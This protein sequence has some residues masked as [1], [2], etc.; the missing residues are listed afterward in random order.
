MPGKGVGGSGSRDDPFRDPHQ[1]LVAAEKLRHSPDHP[2]VTVVFAGG[3][4]H[5]TQP[6]VL[7]AGDPSERPLILQSALGQRAV[8]SL[9]TAVPASAFRPVTDAALLARMAPNARG[10]IAALDLSKHGIS[11]APAPDN[12][13]AH[14]W[15]EVILNG[16]RL[17]IARW[18]NGGY[19][20]MGEVL[21]KGL[22]PSQS[23]G[24]FRYPDARA[25][26]WQTAAADG[27][28]WLRGFWRVPW[29][30][31][32]MRVASLNANDKTITF[33]RPIPLGIGS[34]YG[35]TQ[36]GKHG[37]ELWQAINLLEEIDQLGEWSVD[38]KSGTLYLW[39]PNTRAA[40][41]ILLCHRR[42]PVILIQGGSNIILR[43]M[44]VNGSMGPGIVIDKGSGVVVENCLVRH[45]AG[46]GILIASGNRHAVLASEI[47]GT[48]LE[49]IRFTGG[50]RRT[51]A[52]GDHRISNNH[53]HHTGVHAPAAAII[54]GA[55]RKSETVGNLVSHNRIHDVPNSGIVF[56]GNN[57]I[58][59]YNEIYRIGLDS[60]DLGGIYT[61]SAWTAR[62]NIIRHNFIHHS[63]NANALYMDDGSCGSLMEG[64]ILWKVQGGAFIGGG[65]DQTV[66]HNLILECPRALHIDS[67]GFSRNY[68]I[69]N[70]G[71]ADDLRSIP[72]T[73]D[74]WKSRYPELV[75]ILD[76]DTRLPRN[77]RM[78]QNLLVG[79]G[80]S[81][82]KS[83]TKNDFGGLIFRDNEELPT[84]EAF[85]DT[86]TMTIQ[87][88]ETLRARAATRPWAK[89]IARAGL[90]RDADRTVIP[91]RDV[92]TLRSID[93]TRSFDSQTDL[94][95]SNREKQ[96]TE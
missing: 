70:R 17:P 11:I 52:P 43:D 28:L 7:G 79:C 88:P 71:F 12:F 36:D 75:R 19:A 61:N 60:G 16:E 81:L 87:L 23:G 59:E 64:N 76:Q 68:T 47:T 86:E 85:I 24:T 3:S 29:T 31:Q 74:P 73:Q 65:H 78:E 6:L 42:E 66:R 53:I 93:T 37:D 39:L 32:A 20:R 9:G 1:A 35:K 92:E 48:G 33:A 30:R 5:L 25:D 40:D 10:K 55:G 13:G 18:P 50:D 46:A 44:E 82:R 41:G 49:G 27:Q 34:K 58:I 63:M 2:E 94:D 54:A 22:P 51:L 96:K 90:V 14:E 80:M 83:G 57:N 72:Y 15:L 45:T 67:R 95:A 91:P 26:R 56:A 77:V 69:E 62:G 8:F 38:Q 84:A 21:D 4:Y 89:T